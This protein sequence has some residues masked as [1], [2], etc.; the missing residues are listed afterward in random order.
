M[1]THVVA[2][3]QVMNTCVRRD[4]F[5]FVLPD[6]LSHHNIGCACLD[7]DLIIITVTSCGSSVH[8]KTHTFPLCLGKNKKTGTR[9]SVTIMF[10]VLSS[11]CS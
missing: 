7:Q 8:Q 4:T 5:P 11:S 10:F 6:K 2:A 1:S 3:G 9:G